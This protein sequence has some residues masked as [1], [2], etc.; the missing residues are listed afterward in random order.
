ML[1]GCLLRVIEVE[2]S[3]SGFRLRVQMPCEEL[4]AVSLALPMHSFVLPLQGCD[5]VMMIE[6]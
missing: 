4:A 5:Q 2:R 6:I 1:Y 3:E